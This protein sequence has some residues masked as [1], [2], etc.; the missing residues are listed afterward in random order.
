MKTLR[1]TTKTKKEIRYFTSLFLM[2]LASMF[3][4]ASLTSCSKEK[5][6]VKNCGTPATVRDLS[7]LDG[8]GFVLE[9]D[10]G[11]RLEPVLFARC[12]NDPNTQ[13]EWKDGQR[14]TIGYQELNDR[15]SICM[16]GKAV[17]ITCI[18]VINSDNPD[19]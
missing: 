18:E 5:G 12:G 16:V 1:I 9:L 14:V 6:L 19:L 17:E 4:L 2:L 3:L 10:N 15:G 7:G 11:Q 8:C 13:F